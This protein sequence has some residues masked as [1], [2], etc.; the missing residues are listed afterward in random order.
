MTRRA[1][2]YLVLLFATP[3]WF[4]GDAAA[5][6]FNLSFEADQDSRF[7]DFF[8]DG[9]AQVSEGWDGFQNLDGFFFISTEP[10]STLVANPTPQPE[11]AFDAFVPQVFIEITEGTDGS[12]VFPEEASF[13]DIGSLDYDPVTGE[14]TSLTLDWARFAGGSQSPLN[15]GAPIDPLDDD[16]PRG[17]P[18]FQG[19]FGENGFETVILDDLVGQVTLVDGNVTG[20]ELSTSLRFDYVI[21]GIDGPGIQEVAEAFT[22]SFTITGGRFDLFI[23]DAYTLFTNLGPRLIRNAWDIE[24]EVLGLSASPPGDYDGSGTVDIQDY[25]LWVEAYSESVAAG[26][27][28]DGNGSGLVDAAD[29]AIWRDVVGGSASAAV[30]VAGVQPVPS[31]GGLSLSFLAMVVSLSRRRRSTVG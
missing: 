6:T 4:A 30:S 17:D 23:D 2:V 3:P 22:G 11:S 18:L 1:T 24:G 9:F 12:D 26:E 10:S 13:T 31:P 29:Y 19:I 15:E 16:S 8:S 21:T 14:V 27:G 28:A 5:E 7:F 25:Q 20:V